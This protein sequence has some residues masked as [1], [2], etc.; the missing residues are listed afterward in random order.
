MKWRVVTFHKYCVKCY[1]NL[2]LG[3]D[4]GIATPRSTPP[5]HIKKILGLR[6][7]LG[8]G[9]TAPKYFCEKLLLVPTLLQLDIPTDCGGARG[10]AGSG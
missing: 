10:H 8:A 2:V 3:W 9:G 1:A 4:A 7:M 5:P 6:K